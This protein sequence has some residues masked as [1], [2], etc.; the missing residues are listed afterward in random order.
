MSAKVGVGNDGT[1]FW[2]EGGT[3]GVDHDLTDEQ[4]TV[5]K[6]VSSPSGVTNLTFTRTAT[7]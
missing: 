2:D 3:T 5:L 7:A 4:W 1:R 6:A